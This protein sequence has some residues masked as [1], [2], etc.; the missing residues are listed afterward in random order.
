[1]GPIRARWFLLAHSSVRFTRFIGDKHL[2]RDLHRVD[3]RRQGQRVL[4]G[5]KFEGSADS[6]HGAVTCRRFRPFF[7]ET[8]GLRSRR[9]E[10]RILCGALERIVIAAEIEAIRA[11]SRNNGRPSRR[12]GKPSRAVAL[13]DSLGCSLKAYGPEGRR[14]C[15]GHV[16]RGPAAGLMFLAPRAR[17]AAPAE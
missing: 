6:R 3:R 13:C 10:V 11:H 7:A 9:S 8:D 15:P 4:G 14:S 5:D 2:K 17:G 16:P 12:P 1:M